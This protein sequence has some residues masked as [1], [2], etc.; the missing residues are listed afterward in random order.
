MLGVVP[1]KPY[2]T[3]HVLQHDVLHVD[4]FH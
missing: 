2:I 1:G 3:F 4:L